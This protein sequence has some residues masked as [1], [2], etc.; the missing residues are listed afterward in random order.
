MTLSLRDDFARAWQGR[1][2]FAEVEALQGK[3]YRNVKGRR[4]LQFEFEGRAYFAKIHHGIGWSEII[5]NLLTL[6]LPILGAEN[7]WQAIARLTQL[8][9]ATMTAVAYG[10]RGWNPARRVSFIVTEALQHTISLE[11][12]CARWVQ[13][14]PPLAR[15][16]RLLDALASIS[17]TLHHH[18]ICHRDY[19]LCHFLLH[20]E[21]AFEAG[22]LPR[23]SLIDLHRALID[24][25]LPRRWVIKD[26]AGLYFSALHVGL[27][28]HDFLRFVKCYSGKSLREAL[29]EDAVFWNA[30]QKKAQQLDRKINH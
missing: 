22:A 10:S 6:R 27:N 24:E 4:T 28:R 23:L 29:S 17:R 25:H 30:V 19:Y 14:R 8:G 3:I 13:Q 16:R 15:K 1:D 2:P 21:A 20:D 11:D 7:E 5:K 26:V 12:Y 18:G 9:V